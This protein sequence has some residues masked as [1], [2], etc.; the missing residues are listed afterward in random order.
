MDPLSPKS[1]AQATVFTPTTPGDWSPPPT[2][3][4]EALDQLAAKE[5]PADRAE[6]VLF[7]PDSPGDW[8]PVPTEVAEALDQL[9]ARGIGTVDASDVSYEP[10]SPGDWPVVPTDVAEALDVLATQP[11][12]PTTPGDWSP[13]P[14]YVK[15][16]LDQLAARPQGGGIPITGTPTA[17]QVPTATSPTEASWQDLPAPP[18]P[19]AKSFL[20]ATLTAPQVTNLVGFGDHLMFDYAVALGGSN[21]SLDTTSAYT[22]TLAVPSIGRVTLAANHTYKITFNPNY[23]AGTGTI[24]FDIRSAL[25]GGGLSV[26]TRLGDPSGDFASGAPIITVVSPWATEV[27]QVLILIN[28]GMTQIGTTGPTV[29]MPTLL[30]EEIA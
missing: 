29:L 8:S 9:A 5:E 15:D 3:V 12:V 26:A 10:D 22:Q 30:I 7:D 2:N 14:S 17:G 23:V 20:F 13:E 11:Y 25:T 21:I 16:A 24:H 18:A 27:F 19:A 28:T 6:D 4:T 1:N